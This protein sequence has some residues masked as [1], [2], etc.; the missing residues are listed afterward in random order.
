MQKHG[1]SSN[2]LFNIK[3]SFFQNNDELLKQYD[4]RLIELNFIVIDDDW[5]RNYNKIKNL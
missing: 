2:H 1:K 3:K 5:M 4:G